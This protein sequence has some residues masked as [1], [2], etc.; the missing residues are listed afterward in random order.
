MK[1]FCIRD[2]STYIIPCGYDN[3]VT[4]GGTR[5]YCNFDTTVDPFAAKSVKYRCIQILPELQNASVL[6]TWVGLRPH[7]YSVRVETEI[8]DKLKVWSHDHIT[9]SNCAHE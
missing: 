7:R 2:G 9:S 6:R 1:N 4:L 8:R 5:D 3:A